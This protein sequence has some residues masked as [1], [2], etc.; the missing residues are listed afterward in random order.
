MYSVKRCRKMVWMK[1]RNVLAMM[2]ALMLVF[3]V[4]AWDMPVVKA[5]EPVSTEESA[6]TPEPTA[7]PTPEP[8][9]EPTPEPTQEPTP[10]PM[11]GLEDGKL[12]EDTGVMLNAEGD[13]FEGEGT[14]ADPYLIADAD[15]LATLASLVNSGSSPYADKH[16]LQ[17]QDID[18]SAYENWTPI[19]QNRSDKLFTG[20]YDGNN[21]KI[22]NLKI[23]RASVDPLI[24]GLFGY[25][26]GTVKNIAKLSGSISIQL[27]QD[28][29]VGGLVADL[30]GGLENCHSNIDINIDMGNNK[31]NADIGG[32]AGGAFSGSHIWGCSFSGSI[33]A[34]N[35]GRFKTGGIVG[36]MDDNC[37]IERCANNGLIMA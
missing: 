37:E 23:S 3:S 7:E 13:P 36:R 30:T 22:I 6:I 21:M 16:Y 14:E 17:I 20:I 1:M 28:A 9:I 24:Y 2:L 12:I 33:I 31:N 8:T 18:L 29:Y 32:I 26:N 15:D 27:Q 10:E 35:G 11:A 19:G 5:V 4:W 25:M 34:Q